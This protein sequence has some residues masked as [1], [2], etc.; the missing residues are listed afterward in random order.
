M[1]TLLTTNA[2]FLKGRFLSQP[3][4]AVES[5]Y[6]NSLLV[7]FSRSTAVVEMSLASSL[8]AHNSSLGI[9]SSFIEATV[10]FAVSRVTVT[11]AFLCR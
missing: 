5:H 6:P 7:G 2:I 11:V 3:S 8:A 4:T 9:D 10:V 1:A